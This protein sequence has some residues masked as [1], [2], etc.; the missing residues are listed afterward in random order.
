LHALHE[1]AGRLIDETEPPPMTDAAGP[2]P[3]TAA[4][5]N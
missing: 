4:A 5:P 2:A 3:A 1:S